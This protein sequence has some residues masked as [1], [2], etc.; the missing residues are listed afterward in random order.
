MKLARYLVPIAVLA[1]APGTAMA[2]QH[3]EQAQSD[4]RASI[5]F[6]D[7]VGIWDWRSDGDQTVYLQDS[8]RQWYRAELFGPAP[9]L[10]FVEFIGIDA[11]PTGTLDK[12]G[13]EIGRAHV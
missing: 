6:A 8:R 1:M 9:E 3:Q 11:G 7:T 5:P 12:F 13:A 4:S 10:P 2:D